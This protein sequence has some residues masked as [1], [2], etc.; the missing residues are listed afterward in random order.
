[1]EVKI[2]FIW[3]A[4]WSGVRNL[5]LDDIIEAGPSPSIWHD[6]SHCL[7]R[8]PVPLF[9]IYMRDEML[10][11]KWTVEIRV[12]AVSSDAGSCGE[13]CLLRRG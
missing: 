2:K 3:D 10:L 5:C 12:G 4:T 8:W 13:I 1:M 6:L 7:S 9:G 11:L